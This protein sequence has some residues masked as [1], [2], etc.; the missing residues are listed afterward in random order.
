MAQSE[1]VIGFRQTLSEPHGVT[2]SDQRNEFADAAGA[3]S[4]FD[5][6]VGDV[7]APV[8]P[9]RFKAANNV[10]A[11]DFARG[12]SFRPSLVIAFPIQR[13]DVLLHFTAC[14]CEGVAQRLTHGVAHGC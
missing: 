13:H 11:S 14:L 1:D 8:E 10:F 3:R 7:E 5:A 2:L 9:L 12:T 6:I 4:V